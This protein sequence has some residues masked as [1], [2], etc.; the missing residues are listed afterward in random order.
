MGF[1]DSPSP[2]S[3]LHPLARCVISART[4]DLSDPLFPQL[5]NNRVFL[6]PRPRTT[7]VRIKDN[8]NNT[9]RR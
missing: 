8:N 6:P 5:Q 2:D 7:T 9:P 3:Q 1:G 4:L